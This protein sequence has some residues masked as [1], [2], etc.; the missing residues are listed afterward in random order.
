VWVV[1][2]QQ[3]NGSK[4]KVLGSKKDADEEEEEEANDDDYS[5][6]EMRHQAA[7]DTD[8]EIRSIRMTFASN[9][10]LFC[11]HEFNL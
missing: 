7:L 5:A 3:Y 1:L 2:S 6:V 10:E 4:T 8:R 9:L 11:L